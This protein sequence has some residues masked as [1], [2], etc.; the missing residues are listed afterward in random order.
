[1]P[2]RNRLLPPAANAA[3]VWHKN[4]AIKAQFLLISR[5]NIVC[6]DDYGVVRRCG[7]LCQRVARA[8][9]S[10]GR[11]QAAQLQVASSCEVAST[12]YACEI[13]AA[14]TL[15]QPQQ[16]QQQRASCCCRFNAFSWC[17][18]ILLPNCLSVRHMLKLLSAF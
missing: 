10:N 6:R 18:L 7:K 12:S 8:R 4:V 13:V 3:S 1:M 14:S 5:C 16:Q 9:P 2:C 17:E 15:W 11:W